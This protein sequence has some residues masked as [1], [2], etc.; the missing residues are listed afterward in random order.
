MIDLDAL[1][2]RIEELVRLMVDAATSLPELVDCASAAASL[3]NTEL[4]EAVAE[5]I[6][7][8]AET[9]IASSSSWSAE[10]NYSK[11]DAWAQTGHRA[12]LLAEAY[13]LIAPPLRARSRPNGAGTRRTPAR[14]A[15]ADVQ[16]LI[17]TP[18]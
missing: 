1:Q 5:R 3:G 12:Q 16:P 13:G 14:R 8:E 4:L 6:A 10:L 15:P 11:V 9:A 7:E 18:R 2:A 17:T